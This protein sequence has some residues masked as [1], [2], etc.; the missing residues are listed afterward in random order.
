MSGLTAVGCNI[1]AGGFSLG[2]ETQFRVLA[3]L[4]HDAYGVSTFRLNRPYIPVFHGKERWPS[5]EHVDLLYANPPCAIVSQCGRSL[6]DPES[7]RIDP[8]TQRH[9]DIVDLAVALRPRVLV[10][11]SVTQLLTRARPLID[12]EAATLA[13]AGYTVSHLLV[14]T[15]WH[16]VPQRR[17]RY[18]MLAH[19]EPLA[20]ERL[21]YAPPDTVGEVLATVPDPGWVPPVNPAYAALAAATAPGHKLVEAWDR[22]NPGATSHRGRPGFLTQR[23]GADRPMNVFYGGHHLWHPSEPRPIGL[24]EAVAL[25]GFPADYQFTAPGPAFSELARGVMPAMAAWLARQVATSLRGGAG[26]E[27]LPADGQQRTVDLR[28]APA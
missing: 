27:A 23:L 8:R 7:W 12:E 5:F 3:H 20:L 9:R 15:A 26:G 24:N 28:R 17:R 22:A 18:F 13:G 6:G 1:Y 21:N 16:G 4:E 2:V 10:V 11:E 14:D 19:R 25:C